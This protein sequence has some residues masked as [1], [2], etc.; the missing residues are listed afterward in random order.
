M[1][2]YR[3]AAATADAAYPKAPP[4]HPAERY[5]EYSGIVSDEPNGAYAAVRE[6]FVLL[7][8]DASRAGTPAWNPL[9]E[10]VKPGD[11]VLLKPNWVVDTHPR[12]PN[13]LEYTITHGSVIRAVADYVAIALAGR[14]RIVVADAPQ[15]DSAF[16]AI[17]DASGMPQMAAYFATRGIDFRIVDLRAEEWVNRDGVIV[18]RR[19]LPGDPNGYAIVDL[20]A[21]SEFA[22]YRGEGRYYGADYDVSF[23]NRNHAGNTHRYSLAR[24]ALDCD[25]FINLPKLKTHKKGGI[26]CSLKNLVGINGDKNYLPHHTV[27]SPENGGDQFPVRAGK[28]TIEHRAAAMLR[29]LSLVIPKAGP[30]VLRGAR[31]VGKRIFGDGGATIRS[32]NWHGNDT[33]WRMTLDM[34]RALLYW[35]AA[36]DGIDPAAPRRRYLSVVDG[37]VAGEGNGPMDP[38]RRPFGAVLAGTNAAAVDAASAVLMGFDP[39][40]IPT[41]RNAFAEHALPIAHGEWREVAIASNR[42][43]WRGRLGAIDLRAT[44]PFAPH[45]GWKGVI[46]RTALDRR[47][48]S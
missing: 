43:G 3:V 41:I 36:R 12:D 40:R 39:D 14:G 6:A 16:S 37:I 29:K 18:E 24:T 35:S 31:R 42:D 48:A 28:S 9:G 15:T 2:D 19:K 38:D 47:H 45:F 33:V 22:G 32:G 20:G 7:G 1:S 25:V 26:T 17:V 5:P 21:A 46:E 23:V 8:F 10:I 34:N 44:P 27:G 13:G 11:V 4:F 30:L